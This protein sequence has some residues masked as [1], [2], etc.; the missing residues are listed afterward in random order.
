[1]S[2][3][4][5]D[6]ARTARS[7]ATGRA[8][9]AAAVIVF[10]GSNGDRDLFE[11]FE[12]AGFAPAYHPSSEP[13]PEGS[14]Q[15]AGLP[16][17]FSYGDYWRAGM[18]ARFAPAV[19]SLGEFADRGGL[20]IGIC[21]GFQTLVEAGLLPGALSYNTP[22]GFRH[23]WLTIHTQASRP[24]PW[25][26]GIAAGTR[27][28]VPMAHGEGNYYHPGGIGAL[29]GSIPLVYEKNPNG[30]I[31]DCAGLLDPTGRI[32]GVMP[33]P[34]RAS[35]PDLGSADGMQIFTAA[36]RALGGTP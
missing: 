3:P 15:V 20:V 26:D 24:S 4:S 30:S 23:R 33:H 36:C 22:P 14:F 29:E 12:R 28:Y 13:L 8:R 2:S 27:M 9:P 17:G 18:L 19:R 11:T 25:L 10:P 31:G 21:N 6:H 32:L 7:G 35:D 16:G 1:M 5:R 34:E